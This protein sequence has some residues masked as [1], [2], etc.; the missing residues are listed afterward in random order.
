LSI[1]KIDY[2]ISMETLELER[3][4]KKNDQTISRVY[5][6]LGYSSMETAL[7]TQSLNKLL[8]DYQVHYQKLR[9][10]HWN[11]KGDDFFEFHDKFEELYIEAQANIDEVA[12]RIRVYGQTPLSTLKEYLDNADI[13]EARA[14]LG[15]REMAREI[16]HDF[17]S[18]VNQMNEVVTAAQ[19]TDDN[20]TLDLINSFVRKIEK[21]HW[22]LSAYLNEKA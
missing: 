16:L 14:D 5:R 9:N 22:M 21:H 10:F 4:K 20:A 13:R 12:E 3:N 15:T 1:L 18:L 19:E 8:A 7:I 11:V 6:K 2:L 17:Q